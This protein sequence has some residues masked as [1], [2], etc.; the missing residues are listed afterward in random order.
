MCRK[1]N[2]WSLL[3]I[4]WKERLNFGGKECVA[5]YNRAAKELELMELKQR[6]MT[7]AGYTNK[8]K[9]LCRFSKVYQGTPECYK[10]WKYIKYK[11][12]L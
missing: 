9:E 5:Y 1:I 12:D 4:S 3:L 10:E 8:F 2:L 7:V 6:S 11:G